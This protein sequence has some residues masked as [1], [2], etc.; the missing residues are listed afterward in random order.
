MFIIV[1]L[2][3]V[4][5]EGNIT[6]FATEACHITHRLHITDVYNMATDL[7]LGFFFF[8]FFFL[9]KIRLFNFT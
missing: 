1:Q 7:C 4:D 3:S 9:N 8:F 2:A 5:P 6:N